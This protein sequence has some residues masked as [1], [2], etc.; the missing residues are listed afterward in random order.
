LS[1][2]KVALSAL[3]KLPDVSTDLVAFLSHYIS[4][5]IGSVVFRDGVNL[6]NRTIRVGRYSRN[7]VKGFRRGSGNCTHKQGVVRAEA[8]ALDCECEVVIIRFLVGANVE[9]TNQH[10]HLKSEIGIVGDEGFQI[11]F[12]DRV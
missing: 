12:C 9:L 1:L 2:S 10:L 7:V 4:P 8:F 11:P 5:P 6:A 3:T